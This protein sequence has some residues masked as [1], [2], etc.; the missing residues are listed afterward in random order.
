MNGRNAKNA[1]QA[2]N[3]QDCSN[4]LENDGNIGIVGQDV[5]VCQFNR[6]QAM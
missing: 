2:I 5:L 1:G 6:V 3:G 4:E